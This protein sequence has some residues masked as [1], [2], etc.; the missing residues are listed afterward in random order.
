Y[1]DSRSQVYGGSGTETARTNAAVAATARQIATFNGR[2]AITYFFDS[3]GGRTENVENAFPGS[4]P[5]P[6]LRG[7]LDPY[8]RGPR[9][10]WRL[11]LTF[12]AAG[13]RLRGWVRGSF[14]GIEVLSRGF[15]PRIIQAY[16]LGSEGPATITGPQLA[17]RLGLYDSWAHFSVQN[18]P[19]VRPE[20]DLGG[21]RPAAND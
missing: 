14:E 16:V 2:P 19:S 6:W 11:A 13:A 5:A 18:G 3:S 7:V 12:A 17:A 8:D 4:P 10:R 1:A 20:P 15:S 21:A 9:H